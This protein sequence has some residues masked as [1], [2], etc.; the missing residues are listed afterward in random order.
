MHA[1]AWKQH[2]LKRLLPDVFRQRKCALQMLPDEE[3]GATA[4]LSALVEYQCFLPAEEEVNGRPLLHAIVVIL[5][6]GSES[7]A[8]VR[9]QLSLL[10]HKFSSQYLIV[11]SQENP[12]ATRVYFCNI[13]TTRSLR[14]VTQ[15]VYQPIEEKQF[16][17]VYLDNVPDEFSRTWHI[18]S[19]LANAY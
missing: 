19:T 8:R 15:D 11:V 5:T 10:F 12:D 9:R 7:A 14:I 3:P 6:S 17:C 4:V 18:A 13:Q 16:H 2:F 1:T